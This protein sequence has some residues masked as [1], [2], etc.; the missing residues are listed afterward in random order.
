MLS[1][2]II[3]S[4]PAI[5]AAITAAVGTAGF[6]IARHGESVE[7]VQTSTTAKEEIEVEDSEILQQ[8]AGTAEEIVVER[9]GV[10]A[11]F[12]RDARGALRV[13]MEGTGHSKA[14]LRRIGQEL[15][16]RVTQQYVY[17]RVITELKQRD[18]KIVEEEVAEDRTVKIR[19]RN[20]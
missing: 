4:W 12:R 3:T 9:A 8:A 13:C 10:R 1:P 17:H 6:A 14:E 5:T 18:M 11:V 2:I 19:V 7:K 15:I 16:D 20:W